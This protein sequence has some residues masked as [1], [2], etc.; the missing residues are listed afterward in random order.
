M[1]ATTGKIRVWSRTISGIH[2]GLANPVG[3]ERLANRTMKEKDEPRPV[4]ELEP[5]PMVARPIDEDPTILARWLYRAIDQGPLFWMAL[6]A[7]AVVFTGVSVVVSSLMASKSV[8]AQAWID[9]V[10]ARTAEE[11]L[12]IAD[13][14]PKTPVADWARLQAAYEEY[15]VGLEDL[16]APGKRESAGPR[17]KRA[18]DLF[19]Q[20]A[21][22]APKES[23]Q[24]RGAAFAVAR[25]LEARNELPAAIKQYRLVADTWKNTPEA[26]QS[27]ALAKALENPDS[28]QFYKD[29][30][31]A[32]PTSSSFNP[33]DGLPAIPPPPPVAPGNKPADLMMPGTSAAGKSFLPDLT[34]PA[35]ID[36][37]PATPTPTPDLTPAPSPA[38]ASSPTPTDKPADAPKVEVVPKPEAPSG[39][40][41]PK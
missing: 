4:G 28:V 25:V 7:L 10:P 22:E 2:A 17:L 23:T 41:P 27:A 30:Y 6:G 40:N 16:T 8:T 35:G 3:T 31:A 26:R 37:P 21:K 19:S 38:P 5:P 34:G 14:N 1:V 12:K 39:V 33:L 18:L 11:Q 32:Q 29:L 20:V 15:R 9:L 36:P 24:A 13:A